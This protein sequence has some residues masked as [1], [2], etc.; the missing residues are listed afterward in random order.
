MKP[1]PEDILLKFWNFNA[2][3]P[4]QR[5]IVQ[6][7]LNQNDVLAL[8]PTG[9]GKSICFQV[10]A[11]LLG[12]LTLVVSPLIALMKDQVDGLKNKGISATYIHSG[13]AW[14]EIKQILDNALK[15][16][17]QML[18][19]SPERLTSSNF[20]GYLQHLPLKLLVVDEAHCVSMWGKDFR[21]S[22]L[23]IKEIRQLVPNVP[24]CAFTASAPDWIQEEIV[25]GLA[26]NN[27]K[28]HQGAFDRNN[29]VFYSIETEN[30]S[31]LLLNSLKKTQGC[32]IVFANT[33][34]E[35][36]EIARFLQNHQI[37]AH[38][39]HGGLDTVTRSKRQQEWIQ[40]KV[41]VMVCTNAF[42]MGVDK[43]DVRYVYHIMPSSTPEDYYQEAGRAGRDG[44]KSYC[45]LLHQ[46]SDWK[47]LYLHLENQHPDEKKCLRAYHAIMNHIGIAPGLGEQNAYPVNFQA[48]SDT[49]K[50]PMFELY[51][52]AKALESMGQWTLSEGIKSPSKIKFITDYQ[53][54]YDFKLR[55]ELYE[56]LIDVLL[57]SFGGIFDTY[58]IIHEA[59][60]AKRLRTSEQQI[61]QWLMHLQKAKIVDFVPKTDEPL[62]T[63]F[64]PRSMYPTLNMKIILELKQR[65]FSSLKK[66][67]DYALTE[68]CRSAF[69]V[70]HFT[71]SNFVPCGQCDNC[72]KHKI[73]PTENQIVDFIFS[74]LNE[75]KLLNDFVLTFPQEWKD[76]YL[77]VLN[78]LI[79]HGKIK[80]TVD[81][82]LILN[83]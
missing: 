9:G 23:R 45:I 6:S 79:D 72:K 29:L 8:L 82:E 38:F 69:W 15:G 53:T 44:S 25:D 67:E 56:S 22:F 43:P 16:H 4:G 14:T 3:R 11:L 68:N 80:K 35:V 83:P 58:S 26:L 76:E 74:Q 50:I 18:Y 46:K 27:V 78:S 64:E 48:I 28:I 36:Q 61:V 75:P 55:Y 52:S 19:V 65:R 59:Q 73:K 63:L 13:L 47:Q 21:P 32:S 62:I 12:G 39:Y 41:R 71:N 40:N 57:R 17:Y 1:T 24:I 51:Y 60:I 33:R 66:L 2:F 70:N 10:P 7:I 81:N 49:Y 31:G 34:R 54:V 5:E 20:E 42:G 30:K 37:S 77:A